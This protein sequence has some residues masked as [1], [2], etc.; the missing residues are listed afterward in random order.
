MWRESFL[1]L[2]GW[3]TDSLR[4]KTLNDNPFMSQF[5]ASGV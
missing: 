5:A 2:K 3:G 4:V 1:C